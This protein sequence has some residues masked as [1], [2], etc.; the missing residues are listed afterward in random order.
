MFIPKGAFAGFESARRSARCWSSAARDFGPIDQSGRGAAQLRSKSSAT[1]SSATR[2]SRPTSCSR[3]SSAST[4][5]RWSASAK[6]CSR[7]AWST[8]PAQGGAGAAAAR[9]QR[10]ARRGAGAHG[11]GL[12]RATCR[13]RSP[14]RWAIRSSTSMPSRP[15]P[16]A[17]RR[18]NYGVAARLR[19]MPLLIS[20]G[21]LVVALDDPSRRAAVDEVEFNADM[22]VVP[23]LG[24]RPLDRGRAAQRLRQDR[25]GRQQARRRTTAPR[26]SPTTRLG[27]AAAPATTDELVEKLEKEGL[28]R[29]AERGPTSRSSSPTTRWSGCSTT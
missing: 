12:A 26:R 25:L 28:E 21:R 20:D 9:P 10:A 7:S 8:R 13:R 4:R 11:R 5:C 1:S 16:Q 15:S 19:V 14:A 3:R 22:K 29:L 2:S 18:L 27:A 23:V 17:L 24:P 6:R